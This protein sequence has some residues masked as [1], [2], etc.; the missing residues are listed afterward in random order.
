MS[1]ILQARGRAVNIHS[2]Y[3][4]AKSEFT[5]LGNQDE[6]F[7]YSYIGIPPDRSLVPIDHTAGRTDHD[8]IPFEWLH[9]P[10][11]VELAKGVGRMVGELGRAQASSQQ[12]L[13]LME[14]MLVEERRRVDSN[15][16][17]ATETKRRKDAGIWWRDQRAIRVKAWYRADAKLKNRKTR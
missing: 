15:P 4:N 11:T 16:D 3:V 9:V 5:I 8:E 6:S 12:S 2:A 7:D 1:S 17:E 13:A 14:T 10:Y